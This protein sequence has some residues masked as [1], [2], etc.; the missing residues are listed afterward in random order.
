[1]NRVQM[2][3]ILTCI[4]IVSYHTQAVAKEQ[5]LT[6]KEKQQHVHEKK[7]HHKKEKNESTK[8]KTEHTN[9]VK[10]IESEDGLTAALTNKKTTVIMCSMQG[11]GWCTKMKPIFSELAPQFPNA[12]FYTV[13][14]RASNLSKHI[15]QLSLKHESKKPWLSSSAKSIAQKK[16]LLSAE[17]T[18]QIPGYPTFLFI[19][20]G[21]LQNIQVGGCSKEDLENQIKK[22][23]K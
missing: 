14:G 15:A 21:Q 1:M 7:E 13:D 12:Q 10:N 18:L 6:K 23:L 16:E 9:S 2:L 5:V 3:Y 22:L 11:C 4:H 8:Y 17:E 20:E 19:K